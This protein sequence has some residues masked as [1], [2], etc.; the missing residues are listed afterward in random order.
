MT[1]FIIYAIDETNSTFLMLFSL[2]TIERVYIIRIGAGQLDSDVAAGID[3]KLT[4]FLSVERP[5]LRPG[6]TLKDLA[7]DLGLPLHHL[8]A[9]INQCYGVHFN[10]FINEY[11]INYFKEK[12]INEEWKSKKLE[13]IAE[14]SGFNNRN[15]FTVAFKKITGVN[16]SE[17]IRNIRQS[18]F[19]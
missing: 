18:S 13:A 15:T 4:E 19:Y 9:F 1:F 14:E 5:F 10:T 3:L 7:K 8:S 16:P 6:Y 11:R 12:I 17:Y 2:R